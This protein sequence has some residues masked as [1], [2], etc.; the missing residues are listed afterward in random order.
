[1][2][3]HENGRSW[4]MGSRFDDIGV[5][6]AFAEEAKAR[7]Q[8][9]T[10]KVI[11]LDDYAAD[12]EEYEKKLKKETLALFFLTSCRYG[13]GKPTYNAARFYKWFTEGIDRGEWLTS[14]QYGI[15]GLGNRQYEHFNKIAI[16]VD[17][18]R[19]EQDILICRK[20]F[21]DCYGRK[22]LIKVGMG[23]DDQCI[24]DDFAA[25]HE[26]VWPE[27]DKLLLS[28]ADTSL[29][30]PY[31]AVVLEY[32][33]TFYERTDGLI[34]ENSFANGHANGNTVYDAQS[35][36]KELHTPE[37][38]RSCI[39]LEFDI[40]EQAGKLL[41]LPP[42]TYFSIHVDNKDGSPRSGSSLSLPF[43]PCTLRT[44]LTRYANILSAPKKSVLTAL[45]SYASDPSEANRLR[46][47][48]SPTGK[49]EYAQYVLASQRS[50]L[51]VMSDFPSSKPPLGVYPFSFISKRRFHA[52]QIKSGWKRSI[53][54]YVN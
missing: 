3:I 46:Y 51:E 35:L 52:Q 19:A 44:A 6:V 15:F 27:L 32:R 1:M 47:L 23:D 38:D 28:E 4:M 14:L 20:F 5:V 7:Y 40:F 10:F 11:D 36:Q 30:T 13:Y 9:A 33:V 16:D 45:T 49:E 53:D 48:V 42:R 26:L 8:Q 31:T 29:A 17:D 21:H 50:L 54:V 18:L 25:W 41:N 34:T 39:H 2:K 24:E 22:R 12:D 37:S 43:P